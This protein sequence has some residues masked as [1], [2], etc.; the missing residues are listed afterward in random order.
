MQFSCGAEELACADHLK[1]NN[2]AIL[3]ESAQGRTSTEARTGKYSLLLSPKSPYGYTFKTRLRQGD[4][5]EVTAWQKGEGGKFFISS[6][7]QNCE[8]V[9]TPYYQV[10]Y[11][12]KSGWKKMHY[13][14]TF[15][16]NCNMKENEAESSLFFWNPGK[17]SCYIDDVQI[18]IKKFSNNYLYPDK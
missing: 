16:P 15:N 14:I 9:F 6:Q 17:T 12:E 4:I 1:A 8:S 2:S 3:L 13:V 10:M 5:I 18:S 11:T 7:P